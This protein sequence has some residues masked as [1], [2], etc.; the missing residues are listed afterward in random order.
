M[1]KFTNRAM[2]AA[3][4]AFAHKS[5]VKWGI[6]SAGQISSD[7]AKAIAITEGAECVAVAARNPTKAASFADSHKIPKSYGSYTELLSDPNIDVVYVGSIADQHSKMAKQALMA[8][9]PTVVEKPLTMSTEETIDIVQLARE[10]DLFLQEGM[11]TRFFPAMQK[12]SDLIASG[13]IGTV[14]N[15]QGDFG[16]KNTDCPFPEDRIWNLQ[17]GGM[18]LDI[19]MYMAQLGQVAY[20]NANVERI[21]SMATMKNGIDQT[22]LANIMYDKN[23]GSEEDEGYGM[24]QFYVTGAANTEERVTIQGSDGRIVL[25]GPAHVPERVRLVKDEGRGK[26]SEEVFDFPLPDDTYTTWNYPG[27]IGFTHQIKEICDALHKD[28]K[29]CRQ[30][31]WNDSIQLASV[32]DEILMHARGRKATDCVV[33]EDFVE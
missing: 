10:K 1:M 23:N 18:T 7:F 28:E 21:Q 19:G 4:T 33:E 32:I 31:T 5:P 2:S 9:K 27:S 13:S 3:V 16:W 30:F 11:W 22:V 8:G 17:S 6:L 24:L 25:D 14:V 15:V 20:P 26:T 29:E 12:V